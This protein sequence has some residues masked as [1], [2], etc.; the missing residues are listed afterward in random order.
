MGQKTLITAHSG[1]EGTPENSL[2]SVEKGIALGADCVEVDVRLDAAGRLVL[3]HDTPADYSGLAA[4]EDAFALIR[5]SGIAVNCDLKEREALLPALALAEQCGIGPERLIFSG[6]VDPALLLRDDL[7]ITRRSRIFLNAEVLAQAML[8]GS[9]TDRA[10]QTALFLE[11][12]R[13]VAGRFHAL[14]AEALNAPYMYV[15]PR[16]AAALR[17]MGVPLSLWTI[18]DEDALRRFVRWDLLN[19]TTRSVAAALAARGAVG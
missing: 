8:P 13:A 1:C 15:P 14:G 19:I 5:E 12:T 10:A 6:S 11:R 17:E 4:L 9:E 7:R 16:L 18:N 3:T 2:S